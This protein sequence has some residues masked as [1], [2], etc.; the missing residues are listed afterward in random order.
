MVTGGNEQNI[1]PSNRCL[2]QPQNIRLDIRFSACLLP[3]LRL[4][5]GP[6]L[7]KDL[8]GNLESFLAGMQRTAYRFLIR[9]RAG[10]T[11]P[12]DNKYNDINRL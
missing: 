8:A 2:Q 7:T 4:I 12:E 9:H 1:L 3:I 11:T 10:D 5:G 6:Q